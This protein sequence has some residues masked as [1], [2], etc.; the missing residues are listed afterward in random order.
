MKTLIISAGDSSKEEL[1]KQM[2]EHR[3]TKYNSS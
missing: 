2:K 3:R 1:E